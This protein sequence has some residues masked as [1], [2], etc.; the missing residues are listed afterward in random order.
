LESYFLDAPPKSWKDS[1]ASLKVKIVEEKRVGV[2]FVGS[3]HFG[4]KKGML[5]YQ[6]G[7]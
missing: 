3:Q 2:M 7:D 5:E 1:N 4:G 6:D